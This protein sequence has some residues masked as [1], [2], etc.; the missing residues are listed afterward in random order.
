MKYLIVILAAA[1]LVALPFLFRKPTDLGDWRTGDPVLV[2]ISPHN[3]AVRYEFGEAFSRWH[4]EHYSRPVKIDWRMVGGT[5][6]IMR[7]LASEYVSSM[8]GSWTRR[9]EIWPA[10]GAELIL[11]RSFNPDKPPA[12]IATNETARAH[13]ERQKKLFSA[14]RNTDDPQTVSCGIDLFCGGGAYDHNNAARQGLT[15]APWTAEERKQ[16]EVAALVNAFPAQFGGEVWRSDVFFGTVLSTFGICC[17]PERLRDFGI[18]TPPVAWRD[19]ADP[20]LFGQVGLADPTK[21]GSVAKAFEMII[22]EQ[23][24]RTVTAAGFTHEQVASNEA[25]IAKARLPP[26]ELPPSVPPEYQAAV[27]RGWLDGVNLVRIIGAN[28]HYFTDSAGKVT[29][30]VN[31]GVVAAGVA[32]D[33]YGR[34]QAETERAPDGT[35]RML[36]TTP[37]GGSSVSADPTGL[38]RGAPHRELAVRFLTFA[39]S[40]E[41]QKLWNY[42]PGTPG[43]PIRYAL[44]RLP[45]RRDFYPSDDPAIQAACASNRPYLSDD[46]SDPRIDPYAL[47]AQFTYQP[48]WTG[49]HFDLQRDLVR[50]MCIDSGDELRAA[51]G[52]ILAH[53]GPEKNPRAM[54]LFRQLPDRPAPLDWRSALGAYKRIDRLARLREW[55]AFFR[56]RYEEAR[57]AATAAPPGA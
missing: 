7:Y 50:A 45:I 44:R 28:A 31:A 8:K 49:A 21:S 13:F 39:L 1:L 25:A 53:G 27:E 10:D 46:L 33:F 52:A 5:T 6:E 29:M 11:D 51:W 37:A 24:W 55:T 26:G 23:C 30:D 56:K 2:I 34:F 47:G 9:G 18:A 40:L 43:G 41:G 32:I 38:L 22:H 48:R 57:A 36:Y 20:R 12:E 19:L 35:E 3:E 16:P 17:N 15:V 42:R 14:F 54:A 4:R